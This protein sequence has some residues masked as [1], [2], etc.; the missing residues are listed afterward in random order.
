M[1]RNGDEI[2]KTLR[3]CTTGPCPADCPRYSL[4]FAA[5]K[6]L[7]SDAI[8]LIESLR[9]Q[10]ATS[11]CNARAARNELCLK[12]GRY[13]ESHNGACDGCRWKE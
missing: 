11:Q 7:H 13:H 4:P 5:C 10:L 9:S 3:D 8:A 6:E 2:V 1:E 12:C